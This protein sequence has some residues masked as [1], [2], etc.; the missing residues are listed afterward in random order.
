MIKKLENTGEEKRVSEI[1]KKRQAITQFMNTIDSPI[2]ESDRCSVNTKY[3]S[4]RYKF[5][6]VYSRHGCAAI[7]LPNVDVK[8]MSVHIIVVHCYMPRFSLH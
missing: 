5:W 2:Y 1:R 3:G 6:S 7:K 8:A 4:S